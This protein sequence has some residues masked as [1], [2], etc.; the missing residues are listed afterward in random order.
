MSRSPYLISHRG[1]TQNA[2]LQDTFNEVFNKASFFPSTASEARLSE[3]IPYHKVTACDG[4][5]LVTN[6]DITN[7]NDPLRNGSTLDWLES[8]HL[9]YNYTVHIFKTTDLDHV[10]IKRIGHLSLCFTLF[11]A[12]G[13]PLW[14]WKLLERTD[15]GRL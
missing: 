3:S 8:T 13:C 11:S 9:S 12:I 10:F 15:K 6:I 5:G 14:F 2:T 4:D 1:Y 7:S